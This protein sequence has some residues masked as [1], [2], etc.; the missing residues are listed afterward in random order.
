[1]VGP[2]SKQ[3][4]GVVTQWF[5]NDDAGYLAWLA[6]HD[7][8]FV[9]NTYAHIAAGYLVV[10]QGEVPHDQ[11]RAR[12]RQA[13]DGAIREGVRRLG[14]RGPRWA[15]ERT[16]GTPHGCG[17]C[18]PDVPESPRSPAGAAHRSGGSRAIPPGKLELKLTGVPITVTIR[19]VDAGPTLVI[20]GAQ[21]VA[22]L[23]FRLDRSAVGPKS[24][25]ARV[26]SCPKDRFELQDLRAVNGSMATRM[27]DKWWIE[28]LDG[29][30]RPW[31]AAVDPSWALFD[32]SDGEWVKAHVADRVGAAL[33]EMVGDHRGLS[34]AT[35]LL[36][37]KRPALVPIL[38][39]LVVDQLGGRGAKAT[40]L[41]EHM[42]EE[43]RQ[44]LDALRAIRTRSPRS[45]APTVSRS[46]DRWSASSTCSWATHPASALYPVLGRWRSEFRY[47]GQPAGNV[48]ISKAS[49]RVLAGYAETFEWP[50]PIGRLQGGETDA[51]GVIHLGWYESE[52]EVDRFVEDMY[53]AKLVRP[54][55]WMRW[56]GTPRRGS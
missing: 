52:P 2:D 45:S 36:H 15:R 18:R 44:N 51:A 23:F 27:P 50:G 12:R 21:W 9:L 17:S 56:A 10:H 20:D 3:S 48:R 6:A 7:E 30:P 28:L 40:K 35:K 33:A 47:V 46:I 19:R 11:P 42:R 13:L 38:D 32:L 49:L 37:L 31:L 1:M 54:V 4:V 14:R 41:I 16:T 39:S 24:Y 5:L 43:G 26:V 29:V 55:D 8:G 25:D 53:A 34:V 22:E